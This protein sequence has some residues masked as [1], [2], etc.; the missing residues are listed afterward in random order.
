[1]DGLAAYIATGIVSLVVGLA[2]RSLEKKPKVAFWQPHFA[3]FKVPNPEI[4]VQTDSINI[5]NLGGKEAE[6]IEIIFKEKPDHFQFTPSVQFTTE[7][8]PNNEYIIR[9]KSLGPKEFITLHILSYKTL[10]K[11]DVIRCKTGVASKMP[12]QTLK[13]F[14]R[15][16]ELTSAFLL[17]VGLGF[18]TYWLVMAIIFVSK[19]IGIQ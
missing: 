10:P 4:T 18:T 19:Q 9:L 7:Q 17:L 1:M 11:V 14:P 5:Q 6:D 12:Y 13:K 8:T 15:W 16:F 3:L 2:L